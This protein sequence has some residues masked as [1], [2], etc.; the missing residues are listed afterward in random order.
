[1]GILLC[2]SRDERG[3][4]AVEFALIAPVLL[5]LLLGSVTLFDLF[6]TAQ[7][8]DKATFTIGDIM[9]RKLSVTA[10]E[11]DNNLAL[12]QQ[13]VPAANDGGLR[14][15]SISRIENAL[16]LDWSESV[17]NTTSL[18]NVEVPYDLIPT[19]ANGDSVILTES[20]VP[21]RAFIAGFGVDAVVFNDRAVH[22]PRFINK[23]MFLE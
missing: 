5:A 6:R 7:S 17:G 1:M 23:V 13:A 11:L 21:H 9:S 12:L 4:S 2:F 19:M 16:V 3:A 20:V 14:V 22:R 8:V 18:K 10:K 15:S